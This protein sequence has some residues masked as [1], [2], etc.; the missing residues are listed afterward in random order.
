MDQIQPIHTEA[1]Y[2][3][4]LSRLRKGA[5]HIESPEFQL[6]PEAYKRA[7]MDRYNQLSERIMRYMG[8]I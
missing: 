3:E 2:E 1:E 4:V 5:E 7:A 8:W 6:K